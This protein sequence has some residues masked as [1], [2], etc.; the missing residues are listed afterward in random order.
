LD[1]L[2]DIDYYFAW[3]ITLKKLFEPL[4]GD[5]SILGHILGFFFRVVRLISGT[6]VYA[7][8]FLFA[9]GLYLVWLFIPLYI[10]Y[11]IIYG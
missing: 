1:K 5:H 10:I 8:I 2:Q 6:F 4:Y 3:K 7:F 11:R 9:I